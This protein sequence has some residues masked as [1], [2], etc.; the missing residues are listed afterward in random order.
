M[1]KLTDTQQGDDSPSTKRHTGR[2]HKNPKPDQAKRKSTK[3]A[4]IIRLLKRK[5]GATIED[6]IKATGWQTHS[7]R[8]ALTGL[9]KRGMTITWSQDKG[10]TTYRIEAD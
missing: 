2:N 10:V 1:A 6:M 8:A 9:R 7:V 5:N 4:L 3:Q